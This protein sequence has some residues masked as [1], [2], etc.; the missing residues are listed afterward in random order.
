MNKPLYVHAHLDDEARIWVAASDD[1]PG[2][3]TEAETTEELI[4]KLKIMIPELLDINGIEHIRPIPF[5]LMTRPFAFA[6]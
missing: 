5:E 2:L 4:E 3:A 6:A 1:V